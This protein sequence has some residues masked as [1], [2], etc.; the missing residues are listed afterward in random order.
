MDYQKKAEAWLNSNLVDEKLKKEIR[1]ADNSTLEEMF[2]SDLSFGTAGMRALLGPGSARLNILTV[3]RATIGV[4]LFLLR[5]YGEE[6]KR[7]GVA[8]SFDN[9]HFSKEFRDTASKVLNDM[10]IKVFTFLDPH[11]TPELSYTVRINSC[12]GGLMITASHNPREYNGYK[13]YDEKGCQG[14]YD[15][16]D[17]LIS[18]ITSLPDELNVTYDSVP[19]KERGTITFLDKTTEYDED[20]VNK[21]VSTSL[22]LDDFRGERLTKIVFSPECGC[23]CIVGPMALRQCGYEVTTVP[24]QD[25]FDPDFKGT[26]NPNPETEGAY[27]GA[28]KT[29]EK[30]NREG[31]KYNLILVT[32]PDADRCGLAF[33]DKNGEIR[34]FTGN[35]T[36]ALLIDFVLGTMARRNQLPLNGVICNTFVTGGQGAK[37]A[38]IYGTKVR[39]T[40]TGFKYIGNMADRLRN[41]GEKYLFGYEESYGYLLADFIRDKDSLQSIIAMADMTEYYLRQGK[42]L[43]MA[44]E[45][46]SL[47]TGRYFNDQVS[48]SFEGPGSLERMNAEIAKLRNDPMEELG[49][50]KIKELYDYE[51]RNYTDFSTHVKKS[52][53][54]PDIDIN[55]CLRFNFVGGGFVAIRPSGTEPKVKFYFE[56]TGLKDEEA[57]KVML[58]RAAELKKR[59]GL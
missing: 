48:V 20:Y 16:I 28:Y 10:G 46:L 31:R 21:E 35:Q 39:T 25:F 50:C 17:G 37:I 56:I 14:V 4:G 54:D 36:G 5:K 49:G 12:V 32:D 3:R 22:Y 42:T 26:E 44:Y 41:I 29:L 58:E 47:K 23:D 15:I 13:F 53:T 51:T 1:D 30:L 57:R 38:S 27:K 45:E 19:E 9:R 55:N 11:P 24:G 59:M 43:D 7:R 52:F 2:S 6:A 33:L 40:A 8:I 34:R 18:V